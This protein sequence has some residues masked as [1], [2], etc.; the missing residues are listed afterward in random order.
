MG[1]YIEQLRVRGVR[2]KKEGDFAAIRTMQIVQ[3]QLSMLCASMMCGN[4]RID[5][6]VIRLDGEQIT[7]SGKLPTTELTAAI[8][9]MTD[10][11]EAEMEADFTTGWDYAD[12]SALTE[13]LDDM[14]LGEEV[15]WERIRFEIRAT[16]EDGNKRICRYGMF[17]GKVYCGSV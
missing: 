12:A 4:G 14:A 15:P 9:K 8:A 1:R 16:D 10:A 3:F 6:L 2:P 11:E 7:F 17:D 5:R 13:E